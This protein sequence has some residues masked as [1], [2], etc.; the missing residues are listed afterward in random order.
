MQRRIVIVAFE[1]VATLD[2]TGPADVFAEAS[3]QVPGGAYR[4]VLAGVGGGML[5]TSSGI[6]IEARDLARLR[7]QRS[8]TVLVAGG[9]E[10]VLRAAVARGVLVPWL[11]DIASKVE[12]VA[13]VC[14]GA[15]LLAAAG[16]LEG[17]CATTHWRACD[18]LRQTFPGVRVD[19]N[20]IFVED[21]NVWTSA[22][23][24]TGIDMALALVERD[25]PGAVADAVAAELVLYLR[26]PGF[27]SQFSQALVGQIRH[28]DPLGPVAAWIRNHLREADVERL[29][30]AAGL[31]VR[32]LHRRCREQLGL[33]PAKLIDRLR[34]EHA[35]TLLATSSALVKEIAEESGFGTVARMDRAFGRE[36]GMPPRTFRLLHGVRDNL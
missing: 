22:G 19:P 14:S 32:T 12:R 16:L 10:Q 13:S 7:P 9:A 25:H 23:V 1:G 30:Q 4:V 27:Q 34:V 6:A 17:R 33:T 35:Q 5:T 15:F 18:L 31:S 11:R 20:A 21:G 36:L 29:A 26:R 3:R 28:S 2:V 24:T 8:D